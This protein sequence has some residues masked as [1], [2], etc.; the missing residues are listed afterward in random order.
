MTQI[1][2]RAKSSAVE[3]RFAMHTAL[4]AWHEGSVAVE[5]GPLLYA[6]KIREDWK[7]V[8]NPDRW[9][10]FYEVRP[11]D[12]WDYALSESAIEDPDH[13][14]EVIN[15]PR[16][17]AYPWNLEEAPIALR[18]TG[19]RIPGWHLYNEMAGPL[20]HSLQQRDTA[21][22]AEEEITLIPYGCTTL[23]ITEFPVKR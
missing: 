2:K 17:N 14:F 19:L 6:L 7:F 15:H 20:P 21:G 8:D 10:D 22:A 3:I 9:G 13:A 4:T 12:P 5:R 23:R 18:T 1:A 16:Q 11:L